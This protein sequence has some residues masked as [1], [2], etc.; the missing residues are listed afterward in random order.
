MILSTAQAHD[1]LSRHGVFAREACD[2]C[3]AILGAVRY[4]RRGES[5]VWCSSE[6]RGDG[7]RPRI[8]KGGQLKK[9]KTDAERQRA[10]REQGT[11][12]QRVF[13][14]SLC[15]G[16]PPCSFPGTKHLQA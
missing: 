11:V 14:A 3:G 8:R 9:Y 13:R 16:K 10:E 4:A 2:R 15:N 7:E 1:L 12:R 5:G 6:C